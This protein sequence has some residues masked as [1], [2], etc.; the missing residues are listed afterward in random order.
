[1]GIDIS[2]FSEPIID[3]YI[4]Y[5]ITVIHFLLEALPCVVWI[6]RL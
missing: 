4:I 1:M 6:I 3:F 5:H 2:W